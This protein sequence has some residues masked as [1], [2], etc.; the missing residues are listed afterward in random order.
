MQPHNEKFGLNA[1]TSNITQ[2]QSDNLIEYVRL[3]FTCMAQSCV[4]ASLIRVEV[5]SGTAV[6]LWR[7]QTADP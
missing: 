6:T 3:Y 2:V 1:I 4:T 5:R 7:Q